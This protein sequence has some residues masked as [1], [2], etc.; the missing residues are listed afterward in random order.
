ME[1]LLILH[2]LF[3]Q[4][5]IHIFHVLVSLVT[6]MSDSQK[7]LKGSNWGNKISIFVTRVRGKLIV[8]Y[9]I[10]DLSEVSEVFIQGCATLLL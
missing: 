6:K 5:N 10:L 3:M 1:L 8:L 2:K 9:S 4:I 7:Y